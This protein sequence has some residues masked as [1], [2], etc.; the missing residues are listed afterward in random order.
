MRIL[1]EGPNLGQFFL[2]SNDTENHIEWLDYLTITRSFLSLSK[3][4]NTKE[5]TEERQ[6]FEQDANKSTPRD[7]DA[8][9]L[10]PVRVPCKHDFPAFC[11]CRCL[12]EKVSRFMLR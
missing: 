10:Q 1:D 7:N 11:V 6:I 4:V 12:H 9:G 8:A 2:S 3:D 5:T